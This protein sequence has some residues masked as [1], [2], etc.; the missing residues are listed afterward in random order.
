MGGQHP[1]RDGVPLQRSRR[2]LALVYGNT[3]APFPGIGIRVGPGA[4]DP[5]LPPA[6]P[7]DLIRCGAGG[8]SPAG[9]D[10]RVCHDGERFLSPA[11]TVHG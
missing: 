8:D 9:S 4:P 7:A 5:A 1:Y 3:G 11:G 6:S 10:R 2:P